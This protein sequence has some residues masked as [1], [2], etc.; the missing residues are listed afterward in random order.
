MVEKT[1][2]LS[3]GKVSTIGLDLLIIILDIDKDTKKSLSMLGE[4]TSGVTDVI[5]FVKNRIISV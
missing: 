1:L 2:I 3:S 5:E 4:H